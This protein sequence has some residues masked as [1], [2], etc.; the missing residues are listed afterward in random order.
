MWE[1][2]STQEERV[3]PRPEEE[4]EDKAGDAEK[5][6][7]KKTREHR[8]FKKSLKHVVKASPLRKH[9]VHSS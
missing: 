8:R 3:M 4:R 1:T 5:R 2:L 6:D 9:P 7:F